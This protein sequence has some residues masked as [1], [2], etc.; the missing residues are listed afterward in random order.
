MITVLVAAETRLLRQLLS[1]ALGGSGG[2]SVAGTAPCVARALALNADLEVDVVVVS[3]RLPDAALLVQ[4]LLERRARV[5][6]LGPCDA[7]PVA[8]VD[9][10]TLH[11]VVAAIHGAMHGAFS[12]ARAEPELD[13]LTPAERSVLRAVNAGWSNK[14]IARELGVA[15]PT[16]KHH[17]HSMLTKLGVRRRGEAAAL[18]RGTAASAAMPRALRAQRQTSVG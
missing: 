13:Q 10:G 8:A 2:V 15:V 6:T 16:V 3:M 14:E 17:V 12:V 5:V 1:D 4:R 9:D 18:L 7:A 11:D